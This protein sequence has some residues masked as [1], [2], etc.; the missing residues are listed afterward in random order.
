MAGAQ[1]IY[2]RMFGLLINH[3]F[4]T[5]IMRYS[6]VLA[7][8]LDAATRLAQFAGLDVQAGRIKQAAGFVRSP[9]ARQD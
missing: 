2:G 8:P 6:E 3:A 9:A 7:D 1:V 4:P 5:I